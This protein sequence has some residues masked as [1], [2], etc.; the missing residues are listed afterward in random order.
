[1][2]KFLLTYLHNL[3]Y[4]AL[5]IT[6]YCNHLY[7]STGLWLGLS[8]SS[9]TWAHRIPQSKSAAARPNF[10][11]AIGL[12]LPWDG[13]HGPGLSWPKYHQIPGFAKPKSV[14][15]ANLKY[16]SFLENAY[17]CL[18]DS[19]SWE[20]CGKRSTGTLAQLDMFAKV[21]FYGFPVFLGIC[22]SLQCHL[23]NYIGKNW[24]PEA[25]GV[26]VLLALDPKEETARGFARRIGDE[27]IRSN[28]FC[29]KDR[30]L[31][32]GGELAAGSLFL[33]LDMTIDITIDITIDMTIDITIDITID[34]IAITV[35]I[36]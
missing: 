5:L 13:P 11:D 4:V 10:S 14:G 16:I 7:S 2:P 9:H 19:S 12:P 29:A 27:N 26:L 23:R 24:H 36:T 28:D 30:G 31:E 18:Q 20:R 34:S 35:G 17:K 3:T 6:S 1:M 32:N 15:F 22:V 21:G 25:V 33:S 8:I